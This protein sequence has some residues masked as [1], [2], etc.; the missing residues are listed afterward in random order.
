VRLFATSQSGYGQSM[1]EAGETNL[2]LRI[3]PFGRASPTAPAR[4]SMKGK[5]RPDMT[6]VG[7]T[8]SDAPEGKPLLICLFDLEQRPSRRCVRLLHEQ[9]DAL[10]GKGLV[11]VVVQASV[12]PDATLRDW[13]ASMP[14]SFPV[15][16]V[17][18]KSPSTRWAADVPSLPWLILVGSNGKVASEGFAIDELGERLGEIDK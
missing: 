12:V 4:A 13:K 8:A 2:V 10:S 14:V 7:L 15:G 11:V 9:S 16:R 18:A 17:P 6:S 3:V 5:S 1:A